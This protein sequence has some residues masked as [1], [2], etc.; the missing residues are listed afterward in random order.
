MALNYFVA[1]S[2]TVSI[3]SKLILRSDTLSLEKR[4]VARGHLAGSSRLNPIGPQKSCFKIWSPSF[5]GLFARNSALSEQ[6]VRYR[7]E[8][9][10]YKHQCSERLHIRCWDHLPLTWRFSSIVFLKNCHVFVANRWWKA[11]EKKQ[12]FDHF[13]TTYELF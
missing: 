1:F 6:A 8:C 4:K 7:V 3:Y 10:T 13:S 2:L 12:V 9:P 5:D 11:F